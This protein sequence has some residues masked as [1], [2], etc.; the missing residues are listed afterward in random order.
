[1]KKI[2]NTRIK[3]NHYTTPLVEKHYRTPVSVKYVNT[4]YYKTSSSTKNYLNRLS[5]QPQ[6]IDLNKTEE[7]LREYQLKIWLEKRRQY[8]EQSGRNRFLIDLHDCSPKRCKKSTTHPLD[9]VK[10]LWSTP[11]GESLVA[12]MRN[13]QSPYERG[14]FE[15]MK[16]R[17]RL[18]YKRKKDNFR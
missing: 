10:S 4:S 11:K 13:L 7:K 14:S 15:V 5:P 3:Y 2:S 17:D 18:S 1:M 9:F 6:N 12:K 16:T 8:L